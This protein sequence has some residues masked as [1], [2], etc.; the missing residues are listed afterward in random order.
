M[1][2]N[3]YRLR[4][5]NDEVKEEFQSLTSAYIHIDESSM[6][7]MFFYL[8]SKMKEEFKDAYQNFL[9]AIPSSHDL[10]DENS[11]Q[12]PW[13]AVRPMMLGMCAWLRKDYEII[14][15]REEGHGR[16]DVILKAR[17][18]Q[19]PSF[20]LE[21]KYKKKNENLDQLSI[22]A[23]NQIKQRQYDV[24]LTGEIIYI[25]LTHSGTPDG[26]QREHVVITWMEKNS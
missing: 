1:A 6:N 15:N 21:F 8:R 9:L 18:E 24:S 10:K 19:F 4:I 20:V 2:P 12:A 11:Y 13:P 16:C 3:I 7:M 26:A 17:K 22:E 5:P 14:S 23:I 25:G